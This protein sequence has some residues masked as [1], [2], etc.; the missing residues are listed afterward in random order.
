MDLTGEPKPKQQLQ[1][2]AT[3]QST[4]MRNDWFGRKAEL[5]LETDTAVPQ[6][7]YS[8]HLFQTLFQRKT[9]RYRTKAVSKSQALSNV[10]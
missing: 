3:E 2:A 1:L 6:G 9:Q 10:Y 5:R 8:L 7:M 4:E